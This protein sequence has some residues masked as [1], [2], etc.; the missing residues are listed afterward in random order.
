MEYWGDVPGTFGGLQRLL[1][2]AWPFRILPVDRKLASECP[3]Q[4][5]LCRFATQ[6]QD[7]REF[8]EYI[9]VFYNR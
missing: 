6:Q 7:I 2:V 5:D 3:H 9:E 4:S 1:P 8:T